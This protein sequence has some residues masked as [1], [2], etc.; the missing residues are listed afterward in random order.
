[1]ASTRTKYDDCRIIK[2]LQQSTDPG[3]WVL[4]VPGNGDKPDYIEDPQ[5][6]L[7]K[8]GGNLR[9]NTIDLE[10]SLKGINRF[11]GRDCLG[12]DD[13]T[14]YNVSNSAI[15]YNNNTTLTTQQ[16]RATDPAWQ[17]RGLEQNTTQYLPLN[18]TEN[19]C[20]PF[21]HNLSTRI[22]EKDYYTP[23]R[24]QLI[25]E[26]NNM[27][28]ASFSLIKGGYIG[29]PNLCTQTNSCYPMK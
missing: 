18:P 7:Q 26:S 2:E 8:W 17:Y 3:R 23:K 21:Q 20:L 25:I 16:S 15:Q 6:I 22:L 14:A 19:I 4:N 11:T 24:D 29:G 12:K 5:I 10:S 13:Y 28:P 27:L 9:T 1:M